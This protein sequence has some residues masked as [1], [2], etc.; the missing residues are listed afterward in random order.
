MSLNANGTTSCDKCGADVGNG[1]LL[2]AAIVSDLER[3]AD[4]EPIPG[5]IRV[6]HLCRAQFNGCA[7]RVL[8][9]RALA[10]RQEK[11]T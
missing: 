10:H 11:T 6:L 4:N 7:N 1:S 8:T 9:K 2:E 3:D 5:R